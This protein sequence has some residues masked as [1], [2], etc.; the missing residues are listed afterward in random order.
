MERRQG[1]QAPAVSSSIENEFQ[2]PE[3]ATKEEVIKAARHY[4]NY[5]KVEAQ[6]RN[7]QWL[8]AIAANTDA[9]MHNLRLIRAGDNLADMIGNHELNSKQVKA[10]QDA[11]QA[12]SRPK[13]DDR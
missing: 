13:K 5:W 1:G 8:S 12:V 11:W 2:P 9:V 4:I 7:G 10:I 6:T 3:W